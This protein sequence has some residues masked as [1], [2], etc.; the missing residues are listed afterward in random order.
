[1][2]F[3]GIDQSLRATGLCRLNGDGAVTASATVT[4]GDL[5]DGERLSFIRRAVMGL[6]DGVTFATIEGYSYDS[7]G[8]VFELGEVGGVIK[9]TLVE[10]EVPYIVVPPVLVKKYATGNPMATK[11]QVIAAAR[12]GSFEPGDDNQAD[13]FFL[14]HIARA[15][16]IDVARYRRELEVLRTLREPRRKKTVRRVRRLIKAAV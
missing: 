14:A 7:V 13:A 16:S 5:R 3:L 11:E 1:M 8:R 4:T 9:L 2:R 15:C 12:A 6:L 10:R